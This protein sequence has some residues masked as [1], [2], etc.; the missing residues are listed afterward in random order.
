MIGNSIA[1]FLG[2]G[3]AP[4]ASNSFESIATI[5]ISGSNNFSFTSI[6]SGFTH[7]QLRT[8]GKI[9]GTMN[10]QF[11]GDTTA[12]YSN[13]YLYG[14]ASATGASADIS[15]TEIK[16]GYAGGDTIV[17]AG[18]MDI[19]DYRST[20]KAKTVKYL[21]GQE[22]NTAGAIWIASGSWF[23][24]PEAITTIRVFSTFNWATGSTI[25]LYG[26]K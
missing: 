5:N 14:A 1:G 26:V 18:I 16:F 25:A 7:L 20:N 12:N 19:V 15:A 13:H 10:L 9:N 24:T 23:K 17:Q 21:F 22:N 11:N 2:E 4:A 3:A 6:P 8:T